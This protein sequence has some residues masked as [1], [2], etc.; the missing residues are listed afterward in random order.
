ME[1][2]IEDVL[3]VGAVGHQYGDGSCVGGLWAINIGADEAGAIAAG[4]EGNGGVFRED[5]G[6]SG[7]VGGGEVADGVGHFEG[8]VAG[9]ERV[10]G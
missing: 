9:P 5:V 6:V 3:A 4:F 2:A 7:G 1:V 8:V 10:V